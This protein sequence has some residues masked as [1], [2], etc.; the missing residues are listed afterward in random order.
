MKRKIVIIGAGHVGSHCALALAMQNIADEII[1]LDID[2]TKA[3]AH[4]KDIADGTSLMG[5]E[6]ILRVGDYEDCDDADIVVISVGVSRKANQTRLD[7]LDDTILIMQDVMPKLCAT[8][9][10][11]IL[12]SIS[13]PADMIAQYAQKHSPYPKHKVFG[14]GTALDTLRL[15]R[16]LSEMSG[17]PQ[18]DI[19]C[20][21]MGEH[22][23]SSMIPFSQVYLAG[24]P[25]HTYALDEQLLLQRTR[26][27]GNEIIEGKGSTEFGIAMA[28]AQICKA[29]LCD[30]KKEVLLSAYLQGE[31]GYEGIHVGVPCILGKDGIVKVVALPLNAQEQK[32]FD[33]SVAI[34][35]QYNAKVK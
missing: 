25:F 28:C 6:V 29:I 7:M 23:N 16:T 21:S 30:E 34:I 10:D 35:K 27:I 13:N 12:L 26:M 3:S 5:K 33:E 4:A 9:F 19:T 31:Y 11:G 18:K 32:Q 14:T 24:Q 17:V 15:K 1:L 2:R 22:G 20:Y 8:K